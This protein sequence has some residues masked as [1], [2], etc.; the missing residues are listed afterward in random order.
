M[1]I[2]N[3]EATLKRVYK[4]DGAIILHPEN[5]EYQDIVFSRKETKELRII[6]KVMSCKSEVR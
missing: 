4:I 3:Q 5:P 6:G 2:D 1:I